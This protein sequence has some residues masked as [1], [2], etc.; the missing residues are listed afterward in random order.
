MSHMGTL[1]PMSKIRG[2]T[3]AQIASQR[4]GLGQAGE[5]RIRRQSRR[6]KPHLLLDEG[7]SLSLACLVDDVVLHVLVRQAEDLVPSHSASM[8]LLG[9]SLDLVGPLAIP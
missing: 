1:E 6:F 7:S 2:A 8:P 3:V 9:C 5:V 4:T